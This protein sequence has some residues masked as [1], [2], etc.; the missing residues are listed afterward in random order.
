VVQLLLEHGAALEAKDNDGRTPL[1]LAAYGGHDAA[2]KMLL[3]H[4]A[5]LEA[6][7]NSFCTPLLLAA[8]NG[9]EAVAKLL[10]G[11]G[12]KIDTK[13]KDGL[14]A[15][16]CLGPLLA[17]YELESLLLQRGTSEPQDFFGL[18]ILF[19]A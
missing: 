2:V 6:T 3:E 14:S 7:D 10:L 12:A 19:G 15:R 1:L 18:Q 17:Q 9:H 5:V 11:W 16:N 13:S 8:Q 4:G